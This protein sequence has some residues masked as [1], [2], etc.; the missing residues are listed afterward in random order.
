MF[1]RRETGHL[2]K[3]IEYYTYRRGKNVREMPDE[4]KIAIEYFYK[5]NNIKELTTRH[6]NIIFK[7]TVSYIYIVG[8]FWD[9]KDKNLGVVRVQAYVFHKSGTLLYELDH[10]HQSYDGVHFKQ[11][12]SKK[13]LKVN[14]AK[15]DELN[16]PH[17]QAIGKCC[18]N[19]IKF[20][21]ACH[22]LLKQDKVCKSVD[23]IMED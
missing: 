2:P 1:K 21:S 14:Y 9:K 16:N 3:H 17:L 22:D 6:Q 19:F 11:T 23:F 8:H 18:E 13:L 20:D 15:H 12:N 4:D 10:D 7:R 5:K